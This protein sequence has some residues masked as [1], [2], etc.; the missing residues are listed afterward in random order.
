MKRRISTF[1]GTAV[2]ATVVVS[3]IAL[4]AWFCRALVERILSTPH[5]INGVT[6]TPY[7]HKMDGLLTHSFDSVRVSVDSTEVKVTNPSLD[8]TIFGDVKGI[9][10]KVDTVDAYVS[11]PQGDSTKVEEQPDSSFTPAVP[12]KMKFYLPAHVNIA[13]TN[14]KLSDGKHWEVSQL[15]I[16]S[17]GQK[18]AALKIDS[19]SGD[20]LISPAAINLEAD[21][22]GENLKLDAKV[23]T[24]TDS[25]IVKADAPKNNLSVVNTSTKVTVNSPE[26]WLPFKLPEALPGIGKLK[27]DVDATVDTKKNSAQYNAT[28][29]THV[30]ALWPLEPEDITIKLKGDA[31][32]FHTDITME[33]NEGGTIHIEG[34]FDKNLDGVFDVQVENMNA[35]FGPQMMPLDLEIEGARKTGNKIDAVV[36]TR[37]GS[38]VTGTLDFEDSLYIDFV[39]DISPY[40]PWAIDWTHGNLEFTTNPKLYG[41]FDLH[42]LRVL[43]KFDTVPYAYHMT[44]DSLEVYLELNTKGIDFS[45][46]IIY[47]PKETFDFDGDVKWNDP[48]PHTSWNVTQRNGGKASAYIGIGDTITL[49]VK[50]EHTVLATIPFA[51]FKF[52]E[53]INGKVTGEWHQ[54]FDNNIGLAEVTIDGELDA[55]NVSAD[56]V[57]RQNGDTIFVD[58]A[59]AFHN[60]NSVMANGSFIIPNDSNPEFKPTSFLPIQV[61]NAWISSK[62]FSIPLLLE[63]LQDTTFASGMLTGELAYNEGQ[64]LIGNLN[65]FNIEFSNIPS[66]VFNIQKLNIFA[67]GDKAELNAYLDIGGGGWTG[68]TQVIL[69]HIFNDKRHVSFSHGSDNGGTLWAEGFID[70]DL[71]FTG[72]VDANGS[73]Y[74]PKTISEIKNTDL[75]MDLTADIRKG[76]HGISANFKT[77]STTYQ[78]P[79]MNL[80]IP[81]SLEGNVENGVLN[82]TRASTTNK[83][84]ESI[85]ATLKFNIDS[86]MLEAIDVKS[87]QFTI[88]LDEHSIVLEDINGHMEDNA[89]SLLISAEIPKITYQFNHDIYGKADALGHADV[90]F[91]IPHSTEGIIKNNTIFG[92]LS[93]DRLTY[94]KEFDIEVTPTA[95]DKYL[96]LLNNSIAKLRQKETQQEAKLSTASPINLSL[97]ISDTQKDSIAIVTPFATFPFTVDIWILGSTNRP[98][99]RGDITNTNSGFIGVKEIY[100]FDLNAFQISWNDVPWQHGVIDVSSIQNLPYCNDTEEKENE[101]CPI[102]LDIQGTITNPQPMPSS[103]C[104]TESSA[105]AIYYNIFLGCIADDSGEAT[106]WNKLAGKAIGKVISTTANKTLGGDYIGD[107]DMKVM[108]FENNS[109]SD[110]DSSYVK[111]PISLDRWVNNLSLI[112]GYTQDQSENPTYDQALQFGVNYTLPVFQEAEYSHKN[113]ISPSLSLNALLIQKQYLTNTGTTG[114]N[115]NRMEKNV[116]INYTYRYWNPCLL[117]LGKCESVYSQ[118]NEEKEDKK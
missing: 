68:N 72:T 93:I 54:D 34:D 95:L 102:N 22:E 5:T 11:L 104:G 84:G 88:D 81:F 30:G 98:L 62:D 6:I 58:K 65:F 42:K 55:F 77:S 39:G 45:K 73:W 14:V 74:I 7:G 4:G 118:P 117:G 76:L 61:L 28:V 114:G 37:Q 10:F 32:Q 103:N 57:V 44:A 33:N 20:F 101:T 3:A 63:P 112:F 41:T 69:D 106:D 2:I 86:L 56:L 75:H 23:K 59:N 71:I 53:K 38:V 89:D 43:A 113:H 94:Y 108:L 78:P 64:G 19:V 12:E 91:S 31:E 36:V 35:L 52:N 46:G 66:N 92:N 90:G 109:S 116:G 105:A 16:K 107:I 111:V 13:Q 97:H 80:L 48:H 40:E 70:N 27:V 47:T 110:K 87:K 83:R 17:Q 49:D 26:D 18:A 100:Q 99:L 21:F 24:A 82:V 1:A 8:I 29:Q 25:V 67:E 79:K 96:T 15:D 50:A 60:K 85:L 115:E 51:N 9:E